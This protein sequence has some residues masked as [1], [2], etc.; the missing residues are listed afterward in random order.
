MLESMFSL[1]GEP[2]VQSTS[3]CDHVTS[4]MLTSVWSWVGASVGPGSVRTRRALIGAWWTAR[5]GTAA[6]LRASAW[7]SHW[8]SQP[9]APFGLRSLSA[10]SK[11]LSKAQLPCAV[12]C[13]SSPLC[14]SGFRSSFDPFTSKIAYFLLYPPKSS[15]FVLFSGLASPPGVVTGRHAPPSCC[16]CLFRKLFQ[17]C[18]M[19]QQ[20]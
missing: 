1:P 14:A 5:P 19:L 13:F 18:S 7:V 12:V 15:H 17:T 20:Y 16:L 8:G 2:D 4:Q 11:R 9:Q 10:F 6:P 3:H